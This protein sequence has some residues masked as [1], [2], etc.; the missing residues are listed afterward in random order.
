[1]PVFLPQVVGGLSKIRALPQSLLRPCSEMLCTCWA[2]F[3][4]LCMLAEMA[5]IV[6]DMSIVAMNVNY[7][8]AY[9]VIRVQL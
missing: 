8:N 3:T 2:L 6:V 5:L 4:V 7:Y 1:V 9:S